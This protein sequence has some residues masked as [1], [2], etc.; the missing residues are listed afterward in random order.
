[1]RALDQMLMRVKMLFL[2]NRAGDELGRELE[3]HL[4]RQIAENIA[5]GMSPREARTA[6]LRL[7]GN[8]L[9]L[10]Q[11]ARASWSWTWTELILSDIRQGIRRLART[12]GFSWL[13]ILVMGLG[14]G[15]NVAL[16][17]V[18][19]SV[20]LNPLPFPNADRLVRIYEANARGAFNDSIVAGGSFATWQAQA[21][22]FDQMAIKMMYQ[23]DLADPNGQ[24]PEGE[25]RRCVP[26]RWAARDRRS[27]SSA[28]AAWG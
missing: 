15:A 3:F 19:K 9:L 13:A 25:Q 8:P 4:D 22:S 14:I 5:A 10:R 23:Y 28:W 27:A 26:P 12:P 11:Q 7:F 17:T 24:L 16:F 21:H 2:R 20:L 1:M 18:V 6:A